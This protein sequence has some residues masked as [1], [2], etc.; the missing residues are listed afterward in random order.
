MQQVII[1]LKTNISWNLGYYFN[2]LN[3]FFFFLQMAA[4]GFYFAGSKSEPDLAC[5]FVCLKELDGWEEEDDPWLVM[6]I[7]DPCFYSCEHSQIKKK[8]VHE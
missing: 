6:Q 5:C 3:F 2:L 8:I 1:Y 4:A 7:A